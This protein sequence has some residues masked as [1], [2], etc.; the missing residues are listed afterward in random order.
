MRRDSVVALAITFFFVLLCFQGEVS[1]VAGLGSLAVLAGLGI[2]T[3]R[4]TAIEQRAM[5]RTAPLE[6]VLGLPTKRWLIGL[7]IVAGTIA[8]PVG[9][10]LFVEAAVQVA[11]QLGVSEAVV[12]L[13]IVAVG[14]SLP[15]LATTLVAAVQR[16]TEVVVGTAIGSNIFNILGIMGVA[17]AVSPAPIPVPASFLSLDLPVMLGAAAVLTLFAWLA[18]SIGRSAGIVLLAGYISYLVVLFLSA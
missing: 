16:Q 13:S 4:E 12:G 5:S 1:R 14:T 9:A 7:F 18:R 17:A 11:G 6:P 10:S 8:L 15:E 2:F 3:A